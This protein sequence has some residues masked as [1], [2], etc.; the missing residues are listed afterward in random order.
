[1]RLRRVIIPF[2]FA[3]LIAMGSSSFAAA[4]P[5]YKSDP[6]L[7]HG[8]KFLLANQAPVGTWVPRVGPTVIHRNTTIITPR[9][10][11]ISPRHPSHYDGLNV[12]LGVILIDRE[13]G[14]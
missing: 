8:L 9:I 5:L 4:K 14:F 13:I 1:M 6:I 7:S 3:V 2:S 10:L 12:S 11:P